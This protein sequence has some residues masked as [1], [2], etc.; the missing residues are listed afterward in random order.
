MPTLRN[1]RTGK[2]TKLKKSKAPS[3][4]KKMANRRK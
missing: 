1:K 4:I 2:I 3:K